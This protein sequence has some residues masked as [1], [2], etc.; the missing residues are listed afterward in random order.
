[1]EKKNTVLLTVIAIATLLVA[2]VGATFAYFASNSSS[3]AKATITTTTAKAVDLFTTTGNSTLELEV[4]NEKMAEALKG[5]VADTAEGTIEVSLTAGSGTATCTYDLVYVPNTTSPNVA[6][7]GS[8]A[9]ANA[10]EYTLTVAGSK[11]VEET[12]ID[13]FTDN[14]ILNDVPISATVANVGDEAVTEK[15]NYTLTAKFHNLATEQ[16]DLVGQKYSGTVEV[17]DVHCTNGGTVTYSE[18]TGA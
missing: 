14:I 1:M 15:H 3:D 12:N 4:T 17:A 11:T 10:L 2:V 6:Y 8:A 7:T 13:Q 5:S 9:R 16:Q 18:R